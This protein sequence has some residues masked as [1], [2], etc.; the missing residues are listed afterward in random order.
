MIS[1]DA[2]TK[3]HDIATNPSVKLPVNS[4]VQPTTDGPTSPPQL[5]IE[6]IMAIPAAA[7]RPVRNDGGIAQKVPKNP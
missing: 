4:R 6:M 2:I 1:S 5:P 3:K 7:A